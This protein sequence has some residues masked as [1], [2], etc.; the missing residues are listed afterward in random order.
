MGWVLL[1]VLLIGGCARSANPQTGPSATP[2]RDQIV[3]AAT[4]IA[5]HRL[6][7]GEFLFLRYCA[8]CHGATA[9]GDGPVADSLQAQPRNLRQSDLWAN[10]TDDQLIVRIL[11]GKILPIPVDPKG[12]PHTE[13]EVSAIFTH[14]QRLPTL[15]WNQI[16]HGE[17]VYDSICLSCHGVY[18]RGDGTLTSTLTV[19]SRDLSAPPYQQQVS[20]EEL[21]RVITE[22]KG[23]MPGMG[24]VLSESERHAVV[25]FM[26]VFSPG[27]ELYDRFCVSCHG[28]RGEP[29]EPAIL[30]MLGVADRWEPPPT[31]DRVYFQKRNEEQ[32]RKGITHMLKLSRVL[33]PHFAGVLTADQ[34]RDIVQ[35]LRTLPPEPS[36]TAS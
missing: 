29:P 17:R 21:L 5:T 31:F 9:L 20:D 33:M 24:N 32:I 28:P 30:E 19:R 23:A 35:Y 4:P 26:R 36:G 6:T 18:G 22:G 10:T 11:H 14:L 25:T 12:L 13:M 34:I 27:Y 8:G 16:D 15:P 2:P 1:L 3:A 7:Q